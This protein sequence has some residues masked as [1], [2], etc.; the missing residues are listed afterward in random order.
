MWCCA[1]A[2]A[3]A[4]KAS[5]LRLTGAGSLWRSSHQSR[6][7]RPG[8]GALTRQRRKRQRASPRSSPSHVACSPAEPRGVSRAQ[9]AIH[10]HGA[11]GQRRHGTRAKRRSDRRSSTTRQK[12]A[13]A[14]AAP[15]KQTAECLRRA[16]PR[17]WSRAEGGAAPARP[18]GQWPSGVQVRAEWLLLQQRNCCNG[19]TEST[20]AHT[21]ARNACVRHHAQLPA[22][23]LALAAPRHGKNTTSTTSQASR[24]LPCV[25][26][27]QSARS[28]QRLAAIRARRLARGSGS[29]L[30]QH[31]CA[32]SDEH[33]RTAW[34][35]WP[36]DRG[37]VPAAC[38]AQRANRLCPSAL[39]DGHRW[40]S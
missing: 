36:A 4:I 28:E 3:R 13:P 30:I 24:S 26:W 17:P 12:P 38:H 29:S 11:W 37:A 25:V 1:S 16:R 21:P 2:A 34:V 20:P 6:R 35:S 23:V 32:P 7:R 14:A 40:S 9:Q 5:A 27:G 15:R 22:A 31:A 10:L 39:S 33:G 8:R 18:R 19:A